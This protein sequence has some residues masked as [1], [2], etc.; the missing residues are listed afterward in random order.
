MLRKSRIAGPAR[1]AAVIGILAGLSLALSGCGKNPT[2]YVDPMAS[3]TTTLTPNA[4]IEAA[5]LKQ[6][7]DEGLVNNT[8]PRARDKVVVVTV[9]TSAQYTANHIPGSV[10]LNSSTELTTSRLE[11]LSALTSEV[12][13]GSQMD[14]L[15]QK[16]GIDRYTTVVFVA[17]TGQNF[18]NPS[19]AYFMFRY[20]GFARERLKV[21]QGG[22][23]AWTTAGYTL[24]TTAPTVTPTTFSVRDLYD[25]TGAHLA[26]RVPIGEMIDVVDRVNAGTLSASSA[27][28]ITILDVR[29]GVD[30]LVG[31]Y[32]ANSK[33]DDYAQY[34]VTGAT[35]TFKPTADMVA[36]LESFGVTST[37]SMTY[38]YC[39]SGMRASSVFFVLDGI[40]GWPVKLYDGS[41]GQWFAYR[42]A[43]AVNTAWRVDTNSPNTTLP[44]TF[45]TI[46]SGSLT[47]DPT[48]NALY[49]S[50]TDKR[51]NQ[52]GVE[53]KAYQSSGS[54][55][56]NTGGGSGGGG[57]SGC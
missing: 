5:T 26:F 28:G 34:Y 44:R 51:A 2:S 17:S 25:G 20:W 8:N 3:V 4:L 30:P 43:N 18:L 24:T 53:D 29:G 52:I 15:I 6:W 45:G 47:L 50:V 56:G 9:A 39:A 31:P 46:A 21:L 27:T 33:V 10:L 57:P 54:T 32:V 42:T 16:L 13:D 40:L 38:V 48:A 23:N 37:K 22:E 41:S 11:A 55:T 49:L 1:V 7:M 36:R 12:L 19:R 14:A 35:S